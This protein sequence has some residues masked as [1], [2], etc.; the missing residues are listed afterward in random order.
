M[1]MANTIASTPAHLAEHEAGIITI[2][3]RSD[4]MAVAMTA[5]GHVGPFRDAVRTH[6]PERAIA[7]YLRLMAAH[8][9]SPLYKPER[10]PPHRA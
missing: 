7:C 8:T 1:N 6:G 3:R 2:A 5:R 10:M 9:W 4:G